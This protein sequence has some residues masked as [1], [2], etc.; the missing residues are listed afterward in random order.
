M[1]DLLKIQFFSLHSLIL[2]LLSFSGQKYFLHAVRPLTHLYLSYIFYFCAFF[3]ATGL[4]NSFNKI[5]GAPHPCTPFS[6][7]SFAVCSPLHPCCIGSLTPFS[8]SWIR[9]CLKNVV[10][11]NL[12]LAYIDTQFHVNLYFIIDRMFDSQLRYPF[13]LC[14]VSDQGCIRYPFVSLMKIILLLP[15]YL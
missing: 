15:I 7:T 14:L 5:A 12:Y 2:P 4:A 13:N 3:L 11:F 10:Y 9:P 8:N 1:C 6:L